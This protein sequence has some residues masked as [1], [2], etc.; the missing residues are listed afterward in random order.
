MIVGG[1]QKNVRRIATLSVRSATVDCVHFATPFPSSLGGDVRAT[2]G[3][4]Q[5]LH[6]FLAIAQHGVQILRSMQTHQEIQHTHTE[7]E[8]KK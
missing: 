4:D 3:A 5:V 2:G 1:L 6:G 8:S 7:R